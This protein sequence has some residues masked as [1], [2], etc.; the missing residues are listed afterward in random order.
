PEDYDGV[1]SNVPIVNFSTLMLAPELIRIQEKPLANWVTP[2][3]INVIRAEFL[4]QCDQLDGLS[5]GIINNYIEARA[6]FDVT[7]GI[8][9]ADPWSGLRAPDGIDPDPGDNSTS[10][11]LTG[12]QIKTLEMIYSPYRFATPLANG[13]KSFGMWLPS[14][15]PNDF[16]MITNE[17]FKG[18]EGADKNARLYSS[19]GTLG[20]TGFLMQDLKANPLD[21][22]EGGVYNNRREEI[23]E[24]LDATNADLTAFYKHG[25]KIIITVGTMDFIAS[26][27]AQLDYYQSVINKMGRKK[28]DKFARLY[29]VPQGGHG[30]AGK[31]NGVNGNGE[32][33]PVRNI[34]SPDRNDQIDLIISWVEKGEAPLKTLIIN[35][36]GRIGT[37]PQ[38]K[39]FLLCSYPDYPG[40]IGGPADMVSSYISEKPVRI[41]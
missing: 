36:E 10:A 24:W 8:G 32:A 21:Y 16:G 26:S 25:G 27:G 37:K 38:G 13:V 1:V 35:T 7:D 23:S 33:V 18:Q 3:K 17:R 30:L 34:P 2:A 5:D 12:G 15:T 40:Y 22:I 6:I 29:V 9:P 11:R 19:L 28:T 4:R 14:V 39:G 31:S 20:V 41:P